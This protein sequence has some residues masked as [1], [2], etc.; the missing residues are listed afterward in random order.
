MPAAKR[1][2]ELRVILLTITG[3]QLEI[4]PSTHKDYTL[5][6]SWNPEEKFSFPNLPG[7]RADKEATDNPKKFVATCVGPGIPTALV[8]EFYCRVD[9]GD[10]ESWQT[11]EG[12]ISTDVISG[13]MVDKAAK[14]IMVW[15]ADKFGNRI[16]KNK[17]LLQQLQ[18][19]MVL[20]PIDPSK[21]IKVMPTDP[22]PFE[23]DGDGYFRPRRFVVIGPSQ[24]I[25]VKIHDP[26][27]PPQ[28]PAKP[29]STSSSSTASTAAPYKEYISKFM[30]KPGPPAA[31]KLSSLSLLNR[32]EFIGSNT[33]TAGGN[34]DEKTFG[35]VMICSGTIVTDLKVKLVDAGGHNKPAGLKRVK[36]VLRYGSSAGEVLVGPVTGKSADGEGVVAIPEFTYRTEEPRDLYVTVE[37]DKPSSGDGDDSSNANSQGV[38]RRSRGEWGGG[39]ISSSSSSNGP[40]NQ[41]PFVTA[42]IL[43]QV[44]AI[45]RVVDIKGYVVSLELGSGKYREISGQD[46]RSLHVDGTL[47]ML[48][49]QFITEDGEDPVMADI[50]PSALIVTAQKLGGGRN[51]VFVDLLTYYEKWNVE[52]MEGVRNEGRASKRRRVESDSLDS[53]SEATV[54][55]MRPKEGESS[56]GSRLTPGELVLSAI[57][58][59][60]R[61][62][63]Q[64]YMEKS[65]YRLEVPKVITLSLCAGAAVSIGP[66]ESCQARLPR[67]TFTVTNRRDSTQSRHLLSNM[68]LVPLDSHG[69]STTTNVPLIITLR[70]ASPHQ[71]PSLC[72]R[73]VNGTE[74]RIRPTTSRSQLSALSTS[75]WLIPSLTLQ[76]DVG[77]LDCDMIVEFSAEGIAGRWSFPFQFITDAK[78]QEALAEAERKYNSALQ[79]QNERLVKKESLRKELQEKER[80]IKGIYYEV[81]HQDGNRV[82]VMFETNERG[83]RV[84][85]REGD[86]PSLERV[87]ACLDSARRALE[88]ETRTRRTPM[89]RTGYIKDDIWERFRPKGIVATLGF[90]EDRELA[91]LLSW[92]V[93]ERM[94]AWLFDDKETQEVASKPP[95]RL[96]CYSMQTVQSFFVQEGRNRRKRNEAERLSASLPLG[97]NEAPPD[98]FISYAV[99]MIELP[100]NNEYLRDTLFWSLYGKTMVFRTSAQA[101]SYMQSCR[102]RKQSCPTLLC[103]ADGM[104]IQGS[105]LMGGNK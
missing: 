2:D 63:I 19:R 67:E 36:V 16:L 91:R 48:A 72:P 20:T 104:K 33:A 44:R 92:A 82:K 37:E 9:P 50:N 97:L 100:P 46:A 30:L 75:N 53:T 45:N 101:L 89:V 25:E 22:I 32:E 102:T 90:V 23:L 76:P 49:F 60:R 81:R 95:F 3:R 58:E 54:A 42:R 85:F 21:P 69:N 14:D 4:D 56:I 24:I 87:R 84:G 5:T 41:K 83:E 62:G 38:S 12:T 94:G 57:Y 11:F 74:T 88:R 34:S 15:L 26:N 7:L 99:N 6:A 79:R 96:L 10:P 35:P 71:N 52:T 43:I 51:P 93:D 31:I 40:T 66:H 64:K 39:A 70:P 29:S 55:L 27:P 86:Y 18:P 1:V 77:S 8:A 28:P 68:V 78:R 80:S 98:G 47:P 103:T 65:Q 61:E 59:E 105:G 73:L 13:N 17:P